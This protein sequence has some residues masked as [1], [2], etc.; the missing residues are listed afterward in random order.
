MADGV[1]DGLDGAAAP[2]RDGH[3][4]PLGQPL[5]LD[6]VPERAHDVGVGPG[7]DDPEAVA[8]LGERRVLGDEAPADPG[9]VGAG[10]HERALEPLVVEVG[11][12]RG[13]VGVRDHRRAEA[14]ALVGLAHEQRVALLVRVEGDDADRLVALLVELADGVDGAHRRLAAVD[15]GEARE[16]GSCRGHAPCV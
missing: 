4:G 2:G 10:L 7:E 5:A 14:V 8:E 11:A 13:A 6:L 15:D 9:R 16:G 12:E 1:L 3:A